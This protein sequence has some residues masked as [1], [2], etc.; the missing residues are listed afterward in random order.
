M[1]RWAI[2]WVLV[3]AAAVLVTWKAAQSETA[4]DADAEL[5]R[6]FVDALEHV[7]RSYVK[8]VDRR[9][10]VESAINGMLEK[11]DPYSTFIPPKEFDNFSRSTTGKFGGVGIQVRPKQK[12]DTFLSVLTPVVGTPA[13]EAGVLA[14]DHILSV[15][16]HP[17]AGMTQNEV[18]EKLTG[19][20]GTVV[21]ISVQHEPY[22][23]PAEDIELKR[24]LINIESVLGDQH[25]PDDTWNYFVD[26]KDKIAYIRISSFMQET[27]AD[28]KKTLEKLKADGTRG[29]IIDLRD[30]PGGL[31]SSAIE[32]CDLF[33]KEG[34]IVSTK[35]RNTQDKVYSASGDAL[36]PEIPLVILVNGWSASAS[37]IVSGC[38]QD[39][40][41][42][43]VIGERTFGKGSVQ[44]VIEL[45][46]GKSALK[47][48]TASYRR[49]SG[50]NIH[51][52]N[53]SKLDD[54]WG[55]RPDDGYEVKLTD[56]EHRS[57][58][59]WRN[60]RDRIHGK[61]HSAP[62]NEE[63]AVD[64]SKDGKKEEKPAEVK[65]EK[66]EEKP[67]E[68]KPENLPAE[69]KADASGESKPA[70][71]VEEPKQE[72]PTPKDE[73]KPEEPKAEAK[74]EPKKEFH[75]VQLEKAIEYLRQKLNEPAKTA[76]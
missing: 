50:K 32:V 74:S 20:P 8:E 31:L 38:L 22:D 40:K 27:S 37:E 34:V 36:L 30:N 62:K 35:G 25:K 49:P 66:K 47:L 41:R 63:K 21:K 39:H 14:N 56:D 51:R 59:I 7:D 72:N 65:E 4:K 19:E 28:L 46:D 23:Q 55:V 16:G 57:Y 60:E 9:E 70:E 3:F 67:A 75:D 15:D 5:Y 10:L 71:K 68:T 64:L 44:N 11:L 45:D 12:E 24:A 42:A 61:P 6:L 69:Q 73:S 54:D 58:A 17:V 1:S 26:E 13:Y 29:I 43:V 53:D 52:F 33:L 18:V 2:S 76:A 48:T